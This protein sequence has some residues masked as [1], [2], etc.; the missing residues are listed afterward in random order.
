MNK[1]HMKVLF[2]H[3][4]D[5]PN[6]GKWSRERWDL[7]VDLGFAGQGVY[8]EWSQRQKTRVLSIHEFAKSAQS[9]RWV[10]EVFDRG[11]GRLLDRTGLDWWEILAME[12]YQDIHTL[13]LFHQLRKEFGSAELTVAASRPHSATKSAEQLFAVPI[14]CFETARVGPIQKAVRALGTARNLRVEQILEI[15]LDKWDSGYR[16]RRQWAR[17][18]AEVKNPCMLLPSAYSNVTR[19]ELAYAEQLPSRQFLLVTTRKNANPAR[20]PGN[21]AVASLASYALPLKSIQD[22]EAELQQAW[23]AFASQMSAEVEEFRMCANACVWDYFPGHLKQGLLL[24]DAWSR[25][26]RE[27]PVVGV[28]CGDD[29]NFHTRLPLI[30]AHRQGLNSAYCSHGALDSGFFFKRPFS[31]HFLVKGEMEKD[32]LERAAAIDAARIIVAAP[33]VRKFV[34][35]RESDGEAIVFFSQPYEIAGGRGDLIYREIMPRLHAVARANGRKLIVKL[36]PF[37]SKRAR[38]ALLKSSLTTADAFEIV[39]GTTPEQVISRAWCGVTLDSSV[40]MECALSEIP[41]FLCGW[42]D[43]TGDGYLQQFAKFGVAHVLDRPEEI[44]RIPS[45]V[46]GYR[47]DAAILRRLWQEGDPNQLETVLFGPGNSH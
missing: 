37:E 26:L 47:P 5:T 7:I 20:V 12:R 43:F 45:L 8:A 24:R 32:Y 38:Q 35:R 30:L 28:L 6:G 36:H 9:Y 42:L 29:L 23:R 16:I 1:L 10:N 3:P 17:G 2:L 18:R 31:S 15:A 44:Q 40:A 34:G 33:G 11:R 21:V 41:F 27:E 19:S 14:P 39:D 4:E 13:Y 25:L 22:E 46:A